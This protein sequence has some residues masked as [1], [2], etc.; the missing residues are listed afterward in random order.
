MFPVIK[1]LVCFGCFKLMMT[2]DETFDIS[3]ILII[4][5]ILFVAA[6]FFTDFTHDI[7]LEAVVFLLSVKL[8]IMSYKNSKSNKKIELITQK[9]D[10]IYKALHSD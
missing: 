5:F 10:R 2:N 4:T 7:L 8:I 1:V 6:L 9:K 3:S